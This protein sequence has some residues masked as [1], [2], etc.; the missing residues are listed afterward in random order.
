[1]ENARAARVVLVTGASAGIGQAV[2]TR[3]H[4]SGWTVFGA[5]RRG[6][7]EGGWTPLV[8]DVDRDDSVRDGVESILERT[9]RLDAVVAGAGWGLAGAVE[10][11]TI[12]DAHD[13]LETNFWG[14]VRVVAAALP[15]MRTE[16][17]GRVVLVS[18]IGGM[19]ALPFQAFYSA[20]KFAMEGYGEALAYEVAPFGIE[21]TLVEPGNVRTDFTANRRDAVPPDH[22]DPYR[23]AARRAVTK[24]AEDEAKGV[25]PD[26]VAAAVQRVLEARRPPRRVSVG[27]MGERIG[28]LA[29]RLMPYRAFEQ[30][31]K[32]SLGV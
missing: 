6:T 22:E 23:E 20:S 15:V 21:V 8:M 25:P 2:A 18:S 28:I 19:V 29:K 16:G 17:A 1:V 3:L 27:K 26:E 11:T 31:A 10:Q 13:Q 30:A 9:G 4:N 7:A 12:A 32:G 14:A 5:S 24:M